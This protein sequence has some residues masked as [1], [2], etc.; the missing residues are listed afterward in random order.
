ME[1]YEYKVLQ[2]VDEFN[3]EKELNK[4]AEQGWR[5][6]SIVEDE[7]YYIII[8]ERKSNA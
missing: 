6:K 4:M 2:M 7:P 8:F 1:K 3:I 5:F